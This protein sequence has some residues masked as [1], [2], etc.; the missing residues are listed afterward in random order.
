MTLSP[1]LDINMAVL[2]TALNFRTSGEVIYLQTWN[3]RTLNK[4]LVG[5]ANDKTCY[6]ALYIKAFA[7]PLIK[8]APLVYR[9]RDL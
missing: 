1:A 5:L 6:L 9:V 4:L 2:L 3:I 7:E 8:E